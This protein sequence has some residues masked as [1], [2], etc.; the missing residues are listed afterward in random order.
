MLIRVTFQRVR[1]EM[2]SSANSFEVLA[3]QI[4]IADSYQHS[5]YTHTPKAVSLLKPR[6]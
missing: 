6:K 4:P 1:L 2:R 3:L 5:D